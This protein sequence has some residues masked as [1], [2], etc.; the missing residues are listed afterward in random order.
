MM[1]DEKGACGAAQ[2]N[3]SGAAKALVYSASNCVYS[4]SYI[5]C[6]LCTTVGKTEKVPKTEQFSAGADSVPQGTFGN[7]H[8]HFRL[9]QLERGL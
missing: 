7:V 5:Q 3:T 6:L 1:G 2:A 4:A 8:R 9:S